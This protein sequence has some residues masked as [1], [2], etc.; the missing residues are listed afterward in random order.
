LNGSTLELYNS[1]NELMSTIA[2]PTW[3]CDDV[4]ACTWYTDLVAD[5]VALTSRVAAAETQI[6]LI[7]NELHGS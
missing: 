6:T 7:W 2:L 1:I 4:L 5:I 3:D